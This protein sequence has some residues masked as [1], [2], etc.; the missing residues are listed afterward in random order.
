MRFIL[1][2][3]KLSLKLKKITLKMTAIIWCSLGET[4]LSV[5][6]N[7][8]HRLYQYDSSKPRRSLLL[9]N[10]LMTVQKQLIIARSN[11]KRAFFVSLSLLFCCVHP[12]ELVSPVSMGDAFLCDLQPSDF[13]TF[14]SRRRSI[15]SNSFSDARSFRLNCFISAS[16]SSDN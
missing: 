2:L 16:K 4:N 7:T 10:V 13:S 14:S 15:F 12:K 1:S 8:A 11:E 6:M 3:D 9:Y 5:L